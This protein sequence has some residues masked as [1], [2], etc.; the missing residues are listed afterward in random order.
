MCPLIVVSNIEKSR[1][2]YEKFLNQTVKYDS[3]ENIQSFFLKLFANK[4]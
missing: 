1:T 3:G 2:F 4:Y